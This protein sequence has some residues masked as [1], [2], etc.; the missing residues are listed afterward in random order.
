GELQA[1]EVL[2]EVKAAGLCHTDLSVA[3]GGLPFPLPGVLGHEGTGIVVETGA[4]VTRVRPGDA[5]VMSFTSCGRCQ[6]CR[7]GHPAYCDTWLPDNLYGRSS[8][9]WELTDHSRG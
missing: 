5:V 7:S 3:S 8:S 6:S 1:H 9:R 2:V 4:G